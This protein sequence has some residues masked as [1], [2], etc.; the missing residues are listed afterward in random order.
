MAG[1]LAFHGVDR[2]RPAEQ[3]IDE[4]G[5]VDDDHLRSGSSRITAA[6]DTPVYG[7]RPRIRSANS[8]TV[9]TRAMSVIR[10]S[11]YS[12]SDWPASAACD[13]RRR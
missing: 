1:E 13:F 5:G 3:E 4:H 2:L 8:S 12:L 10:A 7:A 6:L 11:R 9:G